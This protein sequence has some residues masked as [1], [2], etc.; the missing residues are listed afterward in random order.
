MHNVILVKN[1]FTFARHFGIH[2]GNRYQT[3][4]RSHYQ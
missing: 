2:D 4:L 1:L 3:L